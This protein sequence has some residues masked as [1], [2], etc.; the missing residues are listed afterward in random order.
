MV[1]RSPLHPTATAGVHAQH[2]VEGLVERQL[3][4]DPVEPL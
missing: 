3:H 2:C 1:Q 4:P